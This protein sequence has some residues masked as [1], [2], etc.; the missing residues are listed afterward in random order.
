MFENASWTKGAQPLPT[1]AAVSP[2]LP[3]G[4]VG[5]GTERGRS[6]SEVPDPTPPPAGP[7]PAGSADMPH[8]PEAA[9]ETP[10]SA[11]WPDS[12]VG[13]PRLDSHRKGRRLVHPD[14]RR[15]IVLTPQQRLLVLD[16]WRRS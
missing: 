2:G 10:D 6:P 9:T 16:I 1:Q 3:G 4:G 13:L 5:S 15:P 12:L 14:S 8:E 7:S 11:P